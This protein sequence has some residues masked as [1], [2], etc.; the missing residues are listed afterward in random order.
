MQPSTCT[1]TC[2][3]EK[4]GSSFNYLVLKRTLRS[5][6]IHWD[7]V[8]SKPWIGQFWDSAS[9]TYS[10]RMTSIFKSQHGLFCNSFTARKRFPQLLPRYC[11]IENFWFPLVSKVKLTNIKLHTVLLL[12]GTKSSFPLKSNRMAHRKANCKPGDWLNSVVWY[13]MKYGMRK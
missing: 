1:C 5:P 6:R 9:Q 4:T 8:Y 11:Y 3:W 2:T 7:F 13:K 12:Q 10:V